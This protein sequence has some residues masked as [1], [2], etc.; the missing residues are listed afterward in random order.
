[1]T[2]PIRISR[3]LRFQTLDDLAREARAIA[4]DP[5]ARCRGTWTPAQNLWHVGRVVLASVEGFPAGPPLLLKLIGPLLKNRVT[6]RPFNPGIKLPSK[7][8]E[9]FV[10][11]ADTTM[12]QALE[13]VESSVTRQQSEGFIP[14]SPL[15]GKL[16]AKQWEQ[17]HCRHAEMHFGLIERA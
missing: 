3:T 10:A 8:A 2:N 17:L 11:P 16:S 6:T 5:D 1:M 9:H 15:F 4:A 7:M 12:E 14:A 13:M